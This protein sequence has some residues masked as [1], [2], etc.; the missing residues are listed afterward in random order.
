MIQHNAGLFERGIDWINLFHEQDTN[1]DV[2]ADYIKLR[3]Y[4]RVAVLLVKG[5]SEDVDDQA[6]YFKQ[7]TSAAGAGEKTL[8]FPANGRI[9]YKTGT[10]TSQTVWTAVTPSTSTIDGIAFGS[11]V[12]SGGTRVVSDVNTSPLH[13]LCEF[14]TSAL[15]A[16]NGFNWFTAFIEGDNVNN[17]CLM[18]AWV[19]PMGGGFAGSVPLSCIS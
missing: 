15:D 16:D 7:A 10:I 4:T 14:E 3:D 12:P 9:W 19:L 17:A 5:G 6:L 8:N 11:S 18:S 1:T 2:T 13:L